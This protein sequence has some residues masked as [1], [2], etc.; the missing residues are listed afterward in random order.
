[1]LHMETMDSAAVQ[2]HEECY[3]C[4]EMWAGEFSRNVNDKQVVHFQTE[5]NLV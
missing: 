3:F 1:M 5:S 2:G 4:L